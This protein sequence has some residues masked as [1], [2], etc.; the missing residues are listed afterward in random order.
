MFI[1][2]PSFRSC[3]PVPGPGGIPHANLADGNESA[4]IDPRALPLN[5]WAKQCTT[6]FKQWVVQFWNSTG[7]EKS[8]ILH[9]SSSLLDF[10][11]PKHS[12]P[13]HC[14]RFCN[15]FRRFRAFD[16]Y[17][18]SANDFGIALHY[19]FA[20]LFVTMF[21]QSIKVAKQEL[22]KCRD[23]FENQQCRVGEKHARK[24]W[25]IPG[26]R[27]CKIIL[28]WVCLPVFHGALR[29]QGSSLLWNEVPRKSQDV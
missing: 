3:F 2:F 17:L 28:P 5:V 12:A 14:F 6:Q 10:Q 11:A 9:R 25:S 26:S 27:W 8:R 13:S 19:L 29:A 15:G 7:L 1:Y 18:P 24:T 4:A 16:C 20:M 22:D 23:Q 21:S